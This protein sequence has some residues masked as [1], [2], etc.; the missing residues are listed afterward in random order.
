MS[1]SRGIRQLHRWVSMLFVL[2]VVA[3]FVAMVFGPPPPWITYAPLPPLA[4]Q[5]LSGLYLFVVPYRAGRP[6]G[7][8]A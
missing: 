4:L 5:L 3:N 1:A 2:T 8:S 7:Q 6:T